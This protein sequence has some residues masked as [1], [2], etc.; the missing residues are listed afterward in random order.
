MFVQML[1]VNNLHFPI[2]YR[3]DV[4]IVPSDKG[5]DIQQFFLNLNIHES[6][7]ADTPPS[8]EVR[9]QISDANRRRKV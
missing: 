9:R 6:R 3:D 1:L 7:A 4:E 8:P 5:V 2:P